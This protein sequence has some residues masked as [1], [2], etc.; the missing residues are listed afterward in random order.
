M[1]R[2]SNQRVAIRQSP[3]HVVTYILSVS[4]LD[5]VSCTNSS[6]VTE[7]EINICLPTCGNKSVML[8]IPPGHKGVYGSM[9]FIAYFFCEVPQDK[10]RRFYAID[11]VGRF[12]PRL[13]C[14]PARLLIVALTSMSGSALHSQE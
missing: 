3:H 10:A 8:S 7:V 14:L 5:R 4:C 13:C 1:L 2:E 11:R 9:R 6:F 12:P